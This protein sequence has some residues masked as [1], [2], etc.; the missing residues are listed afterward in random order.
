MDWKSSSIHYK[1]S[2][3]KARRA[4]FGLC[5]RATA[6]SRK[7]L[8]CTSFLLHL[9]AVCKTGGL[10]LLLLI[11]IHCRWCGLIF[12]I[13][14]ACF[15]GQVYCSVP[16]R[17]AQK[18]RSHCEAQRRYRRTQ[19]GKKTHRESENRRRHG[20]SENNQKNMD[21]PSSTVLPAWVMGS[22]CR[23]WSRTFHMKNGPFCL[24][25]G[26][27]GRIVDQFPR[28]GYG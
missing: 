16:C 21:D 23:P 15:R 22:L 14:R 18:Q 20:L 2:T 11:Q 8:P 4:T 6:I 17:L 5:R 9:P 12:C 13:C 7:L 27:E 25:C 24:F 28:R 3:G 1:P 26:R 19:K 10:F